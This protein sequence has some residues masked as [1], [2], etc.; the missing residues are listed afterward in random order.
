MHRKITA[1]TVFTIADADPLTIRAHGERGPYGDN[2][3][4]LITTDPR[5]LPLGASA[6]LADIRFQQGDPA[7]QINGITME[8]LIAICADRLAGLQAGAY[9]CDENMR[10]LAHLHCA[11][12][13]LHNRTRRV[14]AERA[15]A[16]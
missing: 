12:E 1:H 15:A 3:R 10:A 7:Q 9:P 6:V 11:L 8:A 2:H 4:Y 5:S 14:A 16:A 13:S